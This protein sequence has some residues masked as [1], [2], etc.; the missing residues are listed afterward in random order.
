MNSKVDH[1]NY[2]HESLD[3]VNAELESLAIHNV[4]QKLSFKNANSDIDKMLGNIELTYNTDEGALTLGEMA[5]I[6]KFFSNLDF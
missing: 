3:K 4:G 1:L 6:I 2:I 5:E